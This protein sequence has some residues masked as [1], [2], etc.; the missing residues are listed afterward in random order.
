MRCVVTGRARRPG[1]ERLRLITLSPMS[2]PTSHR[3][4]QFN[5]KLVDTNLMSTI[6]TIPRR[7]PPLIADYNHSTSIYNPSLH[8]SSIPTPRRYWPPLAPTAI[9][10]PLTLTDTNLLSRPSIPTPPCSRRCHSWPSLRVPMCAAIWSCSNKDTMAFPIV[11]LIRFWVNH[12]LL[13][14]VERPLW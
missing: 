12:H 13:D 3:R 2:M 14:I 8:P 11:T 9:P 5:L 4:Y 10:P 7:Y 1:S 6:L